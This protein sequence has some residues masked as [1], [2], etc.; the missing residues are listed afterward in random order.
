M[1]VTNYEDLGLTYKIKVNTDE[2]D[3]AIEKTKHLL[4]LWLEIENTIN[5]LT[6]S[7]T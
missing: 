2:L 7:R 6:R 3:L 5:S 4:D 1:A